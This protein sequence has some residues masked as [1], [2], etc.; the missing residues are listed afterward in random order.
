MGIELGKVLADNI[1][2]QPQHKQEVSKFD[3][4]SNSLINHFKKIR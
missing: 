3:S 1:Y 4:S 2:P